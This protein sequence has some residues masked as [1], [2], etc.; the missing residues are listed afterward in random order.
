MVL[1]QN[2]KDL[3]SLEILYTRK[4]PRKNENSVIMQW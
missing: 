1:I 4:F 3:Q 2:D